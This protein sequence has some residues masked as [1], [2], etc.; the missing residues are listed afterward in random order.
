M[1]EKNGVKQQDNSL[2]EN[3]DPLH[4]LY[5]LDDFE[6]LPLE[7]EALV[8][9]IRMLDNLEDFKELSNNLR[10]IMEKDELVETRI[11][12]LFKILISGIQ[13]EYQNLGYFP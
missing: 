5:Q 3:D 9:M 7:E 13:V 1:N 10:S 12:S 6:S 8:L 2:K 4:N 11:I